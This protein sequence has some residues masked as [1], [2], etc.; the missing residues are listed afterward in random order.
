M[1]R[2]PRKETLSEKRN[3]ENAERTKLQREATQKRR[4]S[5]LKSSNQS[6]PSPTRQAPSLVKP[7]KGESQ[8]LSTSNKEQ[9]DLTNIRRLFSQTSSP[10]TTMEFQTF[11]TQH[12]ID[13]FTSDRNISRA[14]KTR[15]FATGLR[16]YLRSIRLRPIDVKNAHSFIKDWNLMDRPASEG[17]TFSQFII[18]AIAIK[19]KQ[20]R[21]EFTNINLDNTEEPVEPDNNDDTTKPT[22]SQDDT[23]SP[24]HQ[25]GDSRHTDEDTHPPPTHTEQEGFKGD[26]FDHTFDP[27]KFHGWYKEYLASDGNFAK[28][29][30]LTDLRGNP[31]SDEEL[32]N[33]E[34]ALE[35]KFNLDRSALNPNVTIVPQRSWKARIA[36]QFGEKSRA[37][38]EVLTN[39]F[40][41]AALTQHYA[42]E[43]THQFLPESRRHRILLANE[44][45]IQIIA[46]EQA[47]KAL[48]LSRPNVQYD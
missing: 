4:E 42:I 26:Q 48:G 34:R 23:Q 17:R 27:I 28:V 16:S 21:I 9:K 7:F 5:N 47:L 20:G 15:S 24:P 18:E 30:D 13:R 12:G 25:D 31:I 44:Y 32:D 46:T 19:V 3:R 43:G 41:T 29:N 36:E 8:S 39:G 2:A 35:A 11:L 37:T 33:L 6:R 10:R 14:T 1:K 22:T 45:E 38:G 40:I